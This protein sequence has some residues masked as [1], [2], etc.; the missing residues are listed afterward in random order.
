MV[1]LSV[2]ICDFFFTAG[3]LKSCWSHVREAKKKK[4]TLL[5]HWSPANH[6]GFG[7]RHVSDT[8]MSPKMVCRCNLSQIHSKSYIEQPFHRS[9]FIP[10]QFGNHEK[11]DVFLKC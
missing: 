7:V 1:F 5:G 11:I 9:V 2:K 10:Y 3:V 6:I 8:D 4:K